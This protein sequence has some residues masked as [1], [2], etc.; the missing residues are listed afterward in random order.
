[1]LP[2][3]GSLYRFRSCLNSNGIPWVT[4]L[5]LPEWKFRN[6]SV[7]WHQFTITS[8]PEDPYVSIHIRQVGDWTESLGERLGVGPAAVTAMTRAAMNGKEKGL[9]QGDFVEIDTASLAIT[10][11]AVRIDGP[12]GAPAE[13]VFKA[14]IAMLIGAGI[15]EWYPVHVVLLW[16]YV[17]FGVECWQ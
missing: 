1:M 2:A 8:A 5:Y 11:P 17:I 13:D 12:Y 3:N 14:E 7:L 16:F 6:S 9:S 4:T 15:G 10:L